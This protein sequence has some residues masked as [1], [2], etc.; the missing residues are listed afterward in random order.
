MKLNS[1]NK[2]CFE[3][4]DV[5]NILT[6]L[7][8]SQGFYGRLLRDLSEIKEYEPE[9]FELIVAE[10]ESQNFTSPLDVVLYFEG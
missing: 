7:S 2:Y 9:R 1:N 3:F 10:I 4:N 6:E 8:H 5:I